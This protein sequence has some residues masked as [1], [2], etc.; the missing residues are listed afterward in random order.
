MRG[1]LRAHG[2]PSSIECILATGKYGCRKVQVYPAECGEQLGR[3]SSKYG[4][5]TSLVLKSFAGEGTLWDSSLLV[6][7]TLWDTPLYTPTSP[8]LSI[9]EL[10]VAG[11]RAGKL[12]HSGGDAHERDFANLRNLA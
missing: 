4:S 7:L 6:A 5:S 8:L 11:I 3:D 2:I 12:V 1:P 10:R 9:S